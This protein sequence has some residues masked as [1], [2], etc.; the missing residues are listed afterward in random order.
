MTKYAIVFAFLD[1]ASAKSD[2]NGP[3]KKKKNSTLNWKMTNHKINV[4]KTYR[5][6]LY[7]TSQGF[8]Y[9]F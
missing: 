7:W 9:I 8:L 5:L 2:V 6:S 4:S 3:K 1:M